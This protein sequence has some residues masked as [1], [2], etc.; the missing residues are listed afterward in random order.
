VPPGLLEHDDSLFVPGF[1]GKTKRGAALSGEGSTC[2]CERGFAQLEGVQETRR[3][4]HLLPRRLLEL[5]QPELAGQ[6]WRVSEPAF[7]RRADS[8]A[9]E[10][11]ALQ[12]R[13]ASARAAQGR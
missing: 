12:A 13:I 5:R 3:L 9:L 4:K 10:P 8:G 7:S 2:V 11:D 6:H 1:I